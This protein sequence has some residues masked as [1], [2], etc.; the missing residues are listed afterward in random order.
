MPRPFLF[1]QRAS[2]QTDFGAQIDG[3]L[4]HDFLGQWRRVP[5]QLKSRGSDIP[6]GNSAIN[7]YGVLV[8]Y[9]HIYVELSEDEILKRTQ[10]LLSRRD[11]LEHYYELPLLKM[12]IALLKKPPLSKA[13]VTADDADLRVNTMA[14]SPFTELKS[15]DL[16]RPSKDG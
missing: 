9:L 12:E 6:P 16:H 14:I 4:W 2:V 8:H 11:V 5:I 15:L 3:Y 10:A 7:K 13:E 1:A